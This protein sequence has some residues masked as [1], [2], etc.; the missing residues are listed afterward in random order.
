MGPLSCCGVTF[1]LWMLCSGSIPG[2][3]CAPES[4]ELGLEGFFCPTRL[5][6]SQ[7]S[8]RL[9]PSSSSIS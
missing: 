4:Q 1:S 8:A 2:S 9:N 5:Q 7:E 3:P 6:Q